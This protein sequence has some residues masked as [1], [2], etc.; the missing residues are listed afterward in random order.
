MEKIEINNIEELNGGDSGYNVLQLCKTCGL[1]IYRGDYNKHLTICGS[2]LQG[3]REQLSNELFTKFADLKKSIYQSDTCNLR[4]LASYDNDIGLKVYSIIQLEHNPDLFLIGCGNNNIYLFNFDFH[5]LAEYKE[6]KGIV[7]DLC[8]L[9]E[10]RFAST[11]EDNT[12]KLWRIDNSE[13]SLYTI[14]IEYVFCLMTV[15]LFDPSFLIAGG[16]NGTIS[17]WDIN[18]K[19]NIPEFVLKNESFVRTLCYMKHLQPYDLVLSGGKD[20]CINLWN[21]ST[22]ER[23]LL[24]TAHKA[25]VNAI[26][27][28]KD[29]YFLSSSS[30]TT[31]KL[32]SLSQPTALK[33]FNLHSNYVLRL[34]LV[35]PNILLSSCEDKRLIFFDLE[36]E[37]VIK[38]YRCKAYIYKIL[39]VSGFKYKFLIAN[40]NSTIVKVIS[41]EL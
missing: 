19:T 17:I 39:N 32:W 6:H 40:C 12:I 24:Y 41:N 27:I 36:S 8:C 10:K 29:E 38:D 26:V 9:P 3:I 2:D 7:R 23:V 16:T 34:S 31:I 5:R 37:E 21:L 15:S 28:Y 4:Q 20:G 30:D 1:N 25:W 14:N 35:E 33:T 22:K 13:N 18:K 11:S